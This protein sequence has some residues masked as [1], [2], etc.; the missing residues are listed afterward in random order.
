MKSPLRI[1]VVRISMGAGIAAILTLSFAGPVSAADTLDQSVP[2]GSASPQTNIFQQLGQMA[3][4][5]TAGQSGQLDKVSLFQGAPGFTAP[6][7]TLQIW[8]V[9]RSRATLTSLGGTPPSFSQRAFLGTN[10]WHDFTLDP[11]VQISAGTQYAIVMVGRPNTVRWGFMSSYTYS[12]GNLWL[13]C[14]ATGKW[15]ATPSNDFGFKTYVS[16]AADVNQPP[17][18]AADTAAVTVN[19]GAAPTNTGTY[20]DP[21]GDTVTLTASSG[22]VTRT[23]TGSG[24]WSWTQPASDEGPTQSVTISAGDGQGHTAST[25]FSLSVVAIAPTA[26]IVTDPPA[27]PEG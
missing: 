2:A 6:T 12:G 15:I 25:S 8:T 1:D 16:A 18:V 23:G 26:R 5:F 21:D 3:Q 19:E 7:F 22:S 17:A 20:S 27:V 14:D 11:A 9:D 4:T 24:T 13:C 10:A